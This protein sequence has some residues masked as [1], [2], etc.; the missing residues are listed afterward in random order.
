MFPRMPQDTEMGTDAMGTPKPTVEKAKDHNSVVVST[1][2]MCRIPHLNTAIRSMY[3]H[4]KTRIEINLWL[5]AAAWV[6][7]RKFLHSIALQMVGCTL[8]CGFSFSFF[9]VGRGGGERRKS[10]AILFCDNV[11]CDLLTRV[12]KWWKPRRSLEIVTESVIHHQKKKMWDA[13]KA[14]GKYQLILAKGIIS[15]MIQPLHLCRM[16]FDGVGLAS[17]LLQLTLQR[18]KMSGRCG[19]WQKET[20]KAYFRTIFLIGRFK[21][22]YWYCCLIIIP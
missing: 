17:K 3:P 18:T 20:T 7:M 2:G 14:T 10:F 16:T 19:K 15:P 22:Q 9:I 8:T 5:T 4:I 13:M 6:W 11:A 21:K 1:L 12:V